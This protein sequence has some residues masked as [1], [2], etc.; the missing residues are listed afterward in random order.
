M[1]RNYI[2]CSLSWLVKHSKASTNDTGKKQ[3]LHK[4]IFIAN[5]TIDFH[6]KPNTGLKLVNSV[7]IESSKKQP[8][9]G[10]LRKCCFVP[11][12]KRRVHLY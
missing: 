6:V 12:R 10:V 7:D 4:M 2:L 1:Y 3:N 5:K 9:I 11:Q 8:P